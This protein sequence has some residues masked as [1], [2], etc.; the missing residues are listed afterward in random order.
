MSLAVTQVITVVRCLEGLSGELKFPVRAFAILNTVTQASQSKLD[1]WCRRWIRD[2]QAHNRVM[3]GSITVQDL[4]PQ[5][6]VR[7]ALIASAPLAAMGW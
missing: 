6:H 5:G 4:E 7:V 2:V 1:G 3:V